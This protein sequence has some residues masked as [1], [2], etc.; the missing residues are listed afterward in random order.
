[1]EKQEGICLGWRV[2]TG[3]K[4]SPGTLCGTPHLAIALHLVLLG[5]FPTVSLLGK[6]SHLN[7]HSAAFGTVPR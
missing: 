3:L 6:R 4:Q 1:M 7:H 5:H 2:E